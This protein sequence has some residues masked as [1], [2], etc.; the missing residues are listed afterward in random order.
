MRK[1]LIDT[2][3]YSRLLGGD[4][5]VL[6]ALGRADLTYVSVFV[7]GELYAGFKGGSKEARNKDLLE[8]FLHRPTVRTLAA[9]RETAEIFAE[10]KHA[11]K[12]TGT[13]LPINDVWIAAHA[14]E[15]GSILVTFD[16]HFKKISGLR[17]WDA[18][19]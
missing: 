7:L 14:I 3:A 15:T 13:P 2:S 9:S 8:R 19:R 11:L 5:Q 6:E 4:M 1:I 12:R 17:L 10:I 16:V 18:P